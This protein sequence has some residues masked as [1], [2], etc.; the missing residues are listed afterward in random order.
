MY[1]L[2]YFL[3]IEPFKHISRVALFLFPVFSILLYHDEKTIQKIFAKCIT[4]IT[5]N[6]EKKSWNSIVRNLMQAV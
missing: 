5:N 6:I 1:P 4:Q 3:R 2:N